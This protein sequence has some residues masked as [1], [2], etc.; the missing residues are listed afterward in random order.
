VKI[1]GAVNRAIVA[2]TRRPARMNGFQSGTRF[3]TATGP[4]EW[5]TETIA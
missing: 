1:R 3:L 4:T 5:F 2:V